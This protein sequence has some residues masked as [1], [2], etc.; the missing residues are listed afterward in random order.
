[1][2]LP[3][4]IA[5]LSYLTFAATTPS[6]RQS[7]A[8]EQKIAACKQEIA[9]IRSHNFEDANKIPLTLLASRTFIITYGNLPVLPAELGFQLPPVN[10]G[11]TDSTVC[12]ELVGLA[13]V[14]DA[15]VPE[16]SDSYIVNSNGTVTS[17]FIQTD[18]LVLQ[19]VHVR[20]IHEFDESTC[21]ISKILGYVNGSLLGREAGFGIPPLDL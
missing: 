2:Y 20:E 7:C 12:L 11:V 17:D 8:A 21:R 4:I 1:M 6:K 5:L 14:L 3:T 9:T 15:G 13:T 18:R 16:G 10:V 19:A